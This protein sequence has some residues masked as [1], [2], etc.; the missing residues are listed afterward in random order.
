MSIFGHW[1]VPVLETSPWAITTHALL[2]HV[3]RPAWFIAWERMQQLSSQNHQGL[4]AALWP[5]AAGR[6]PAL[7][8]VLCPTYGAVASWKLL[9]TGHAYGE[10]PHR[11]IIPGPSGSS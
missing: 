9:L 7:I 3:G 6:R 2:V 1:P 8:C 10:F 4:D 5:A 11:P